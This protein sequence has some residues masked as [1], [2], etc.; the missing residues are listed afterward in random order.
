MSGAGLES[1]L[2]D[3]L[4]AAMLRNRPFPQIFKKTPRPQRFAGDHT[5]NRP[6][7]DKRSAAQGVQIIEHSAAVAQKQKRLV[8]NRLAHRVAAPVP[9]AARIIE[10]ASSDQHAGMQARLDGAG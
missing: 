3:V 6:V 2:E 9:V 5:V 4:I 8:R 10:I 1:E 7:E